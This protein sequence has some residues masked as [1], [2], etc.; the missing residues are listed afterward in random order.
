MIEAA[1][2]TGGGLE[3]DV[4]AAAWRI[5]RLLRAKLEELR[6]VPMRG[7]G[8]GHARHSESSSGAAPSLAR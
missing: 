1:A 8:S 6:A 5:K 7:A 2:E 3:P 4:D